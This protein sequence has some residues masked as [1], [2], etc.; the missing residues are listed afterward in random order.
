VGGSLKGLR[1][2]I[3]E[4]TDVASAKRAVRGVFKDSESNE[5][6]LGALVI[7]TVG[8]VLSS[9]AMLRE[10]GGKS[11]SSSEL[12]TKGTQM[13]EVTSVGQTVERYADGKKG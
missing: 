6:F 5:S 2:S 10:L 4:Y 13:K 12:N 1:P 7:V 3:G 9:V 11:Q 8:N